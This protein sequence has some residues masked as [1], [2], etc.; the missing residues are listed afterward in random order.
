[1]GNVPRKLTNSDPYS[2]LSQ[3]LE[4]VFVMVEAIQ[5]ASTLRN[6]SVS[7]GSGIRMLQETTEDAEEPKLRFWINP[8][9]GTITAYNLST[10][11]P[12][13]RMGR[14]ST[15]GY[16]LE[17]QVN[18][19][20]VQ[21]GDQKVAWSEI[22]GKPA[23]YS[24]GAHTHPG[25]DITSAVANANNAGSSIEAGHA[26]DADGSRRAFTNNVS[27]TQFYAVWVGNDGNLGRNTSSRRYKENIRP[28]SPDKGVLDV[29]VVRFDRKPQLN[30]PRVGIGPEN[31]I[32]GSKD[33]YGVIAE[34]AHEHFPDATQW[35]DG[36]IDGVRYELYGA[37]LIPIVR[38]HEE[39]LNKQQDQIDRLEKLVRE[40]GGTP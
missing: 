28:A 15:G 32:Q 5:R 21:L 20:W 37:A 17:V 2:E 35:Y 16:G 18:G 39:R 4:E 33:E 23:S 9:D 31:L 19:T 14:L 11:E 34:Q 36:K 40:L 22:S 3:R 24:P 12:A 7:G 26:V 38:E 8:Q 29:E 10:G 13:V 27:G 6:A 1:M 30:P 25:G